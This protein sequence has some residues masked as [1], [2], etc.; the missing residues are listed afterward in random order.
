[1]DTINLPRV[2]KTISSAPVS[3]LEAFDMMSRFLEAEKAKQLSLDFSGQTY[4]S[5]SSQI[6][7]D[8]RLACNSLLE[9]HDSR[10]EPVAEW[11]M[12]E[13]V[14][15]MATP[16][17]SKSIASTKSTDKDAEQSAK[18]EKK[19]KKEAKKAKKEAKKAKKE[20]KKARKE[21]KK[22]KRE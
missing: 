19:E 15:S 9:E 1:M 6:W 20:A 10:R 11:K 14:L 8:L 18:K 2:E 7:N 17:P 4:L 5:A 12:D 21:G 13:N 3:N 16:T 22:R